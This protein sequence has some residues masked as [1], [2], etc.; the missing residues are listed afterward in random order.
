MDC[1][2]NSHG[3]DRLGRSMC[4]SNLTAILL[5]YNRYSEMALG[6]FI[7]G[8]RT[9]MSGQIGVPSILCGSQNLGDPAPPPKKLL[10]L[11]LWERV[12][13]KLLSYFSLSFIAALN[14]FARATLLPN[15][16]DPP[17]SCEEQAL[18]F[19]NFCIHSWTRSS[20]QLLC[21]PYKSSINH[22]PSLLFAAIQTLSAIC[23]KTLMSSSLFMVHSGHL[24]DQTTNKQGR[25]LIQ[26]SRMCKSSPVPFV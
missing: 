13:C 6:F 2:I 7:L 4:M 3:V 11:L 9:R 5:D 15:F 24:T 21:S 19:G 22:R 16:C 26:V 23:L 12:T 20:L 18:I 14:F 25:E 8:P 10:V 17:D 1:S